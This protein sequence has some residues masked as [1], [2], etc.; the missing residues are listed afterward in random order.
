MERLITFAKTVI[1][2]IRNVNVHAVARTSLKK[3]C[4]HVVTTAMVGIAK[5]NNLFLSV[6]TS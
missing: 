5:G 1:G 2:M 6:K 4:S 3:E